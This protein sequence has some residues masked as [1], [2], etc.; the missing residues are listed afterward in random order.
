MSKRDYYEVLGVERGSSVDEI[1]KAYRKL[2]RQHH[3][4]RNI[5]EAEAEIKFKEVTEAH[6]VLINIE[7][8]E[9]YDRYGHA[10]LDPNDTGFGPSGSNFSDIVSDLFSAFM[11][12]GGQS[13]RRGGGGPKRGND[14]RQI[15]DLQ[16]HE[17]IT[18][19][20]KEIT[21]NRLEACTECS[22]KGTKT[23]KRMTCV[24]CQGRGEFIQRQGF[25]ELRQ[26]CPRCQGEGTVNADPCAKCRG[27]GRV[28]SPQKV[29][30]RVP[31]GADTGL[32]LVMPGEGDAGQPGGERGDLELVVRLAEHADFQRDGVHLKT[33]TVISFSQAALGVTIDIPTLTGK[34]KLTIQPGT[35]SHSELRVPGEGMPELR[36]D[37][38]GQP[39]SGTRRGDLRVLVIVETPQKLTE[40]QEELLRELAGFENK[41]VSSPRKSF[42][43][44]L[45]GWFST[46]DERTR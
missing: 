6:E 14:R 23:G 7:K 30:V 24:Q 40:R 33:E 44:K 28:E 39:I 18:D 22:G 34:A 45:K 4:D 21:V 15:L 43:N 9:R 8:R 17:V 1:E 10:G 2:A 13:R 3:P 11:G 5:G 41:E 29:E 12:G 27:D 38:R 25:F 19:L 46:A 42:L 35:Q 26:A 37:R 32:R 20:R 16:L 36:V 31:A